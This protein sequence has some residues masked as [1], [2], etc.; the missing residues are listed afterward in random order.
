MTKKMN[1]CP[2]D[3]SLAKPSKPYTNISSVTGREKTIEEITADLREAGAMFNIKIGE[4][5][6]GVEWRRQKAREEKW[7]AFWTK[8]KD[9][10]EPIICTPLAIL[11]GIIAFV[12]KLASYISC[13]GLFAGGWLLY[14][15]FCASSKMVP[16]WKTENF[17]EAIFYI[18]LPFGAFLVSAL[19]SAIHDYFDLR[20]F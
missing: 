16:V 5:E 4:E 13:L 18:V 1:S 14:Q 17:F 12:A 2:Y 20:A 10:F 9:F 3:L 15:S 7:R 11:F 19:F 8:L 6:M